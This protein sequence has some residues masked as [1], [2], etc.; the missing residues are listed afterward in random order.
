M[1]VGLVGGDGAGYHGE[2]SPPLASDPDE[3]RRRAAKERIRERI[4]REEAEAMAL[5]A[6]VRHE[7]MEERA[8]LLAGLAGG[9]EHRAAPAVASLKMAPPYFHEVF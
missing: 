8:S 9:S 6:E 4:L 2:S 1:H 5:E 7:L 3:L